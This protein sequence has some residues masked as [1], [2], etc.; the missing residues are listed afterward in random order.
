LC[1]IKKKSSYCH[2]L[3]SGLLR[4][5]SAVGWGT[6]LQARRSWVQFQ[7]RSLDFSVDLFLPAILWP[8]V[9]LSLKQKW[10]PGIFLGVKGSWCVRLTTSLPSMTGFSQPYRSP[11]PVT[12]IALLFYLYMKISDKLRERS[13]CSSTNRWSGAY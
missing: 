3:G 1:V 9:R 8:W 11:R 6:M 12:G 2:M 7:M 5:V 10:V 4:N 13:K